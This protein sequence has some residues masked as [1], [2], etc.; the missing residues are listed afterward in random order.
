MWICSYL[1]YEL[2]TF[3]KKGY[4]L[5]I[6]YLQHLVECLYNEALSKYLLIVTEIKLIYFQTYT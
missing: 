2:N 5:F 6:L 3:L 1:T 4:I